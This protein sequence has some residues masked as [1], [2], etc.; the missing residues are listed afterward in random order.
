MLGVVERGSRRQRRIHLSAASFSTNEETDDGQ[1]RFPPLDH[2]LAEEARV[3]EVLRLDFFCE[4][5]EVK[6]DLLVREHRVLVLVVL[7]LT[8][9]R[10]VKEDGDV[11]NENK[12]RRLLRLVECEGRKPGEWAQE[13]DC[14]TFPGV[15]RQ[16]AVLES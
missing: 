5:P 2:V 8:A 11:F 10:H 15:E 1:D 3:H 6:L 16:A 12:F 9:R 14:R 7:Q 4:V 13:M